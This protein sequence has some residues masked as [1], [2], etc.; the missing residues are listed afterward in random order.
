MPF[1]HPRSNRPFRIRRDKYRFAGLK[2][3]GQTQ[4][5]TRRLGLGQDSERVD[6]AIIR[7]LMSLRRRDEIDR[8]FSK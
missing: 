3:P 5:R 2:L 1:P 7:Y 4:H 8:M 6:G